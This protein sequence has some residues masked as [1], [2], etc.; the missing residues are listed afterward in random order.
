MI[1]NVVLDMKGAR[2][3]SIESL[4]IFKTAREEISDQR[5]QLVKEAR[6]CMH[7]AR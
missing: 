4:S 3:T 5:P 7:T 1:L 6:I 2:H